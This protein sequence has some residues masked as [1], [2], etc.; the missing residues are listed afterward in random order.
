MNIIKLKKKFFC[1]RRQL[2]KNKRLDDVM[3][4]IDMNIY[5]C[6]LFWF[7]INKKSFKATVVMVYRHEVKITRFRYS[8]ISGSILC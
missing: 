5:F 2:K 4:T 6:R 8:K 7:E 3:I 1:L